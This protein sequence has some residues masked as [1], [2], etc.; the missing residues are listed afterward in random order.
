LPQIQDDDNSSTMK[1]PELDMKR[2]D[3]L[4]DYAFPAGKQ[5]PDGTNNSNTSDS[6]E[7]PCFVCFTS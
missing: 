1:N 5:S 4:D 6:H 7:V 3:R 2:K